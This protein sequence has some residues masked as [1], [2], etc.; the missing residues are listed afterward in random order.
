M[1][2]IPRGLLVDTMRTIGITTHGMSRT[3]TYNSWVSMLQRCYNPNETGYK[4]WGGRGITVCDA[5]NNSFEAF[6][7]DMGERP[8]GTSLDRIDNNGD[9]EPGNCKWSTRKEQNLNKRMQSNNK[10]GYPGVIWHK[11]A[12]KWQ[13]MYCGKYLGLFETIEDALEARTQVMG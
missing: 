9:Y 4:N 1:S 11:K 6:L 2:L 12:R 3:K 13:S 7:A 10:S 8:E 5:W